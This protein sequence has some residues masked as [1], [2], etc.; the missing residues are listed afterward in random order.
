MK[1]MSSFW[2]LFCIYYSYT[3]L[4]SFSWKHC[5]SKKC[6]RMLWKSEMHPTHLE[7]PASSWAEWHLCWMLFNHNPQNST[8]QESRGRTCKVLPS[9]THSNAASPQH[10]P[11]GTPPVPTSVS[12]APSKTRFSPCLVTFFHDWYN[13]PLQSRTPAF[14]DGPNTSA[15]ERQMSSLCSH[16]CCWLQRTCTSVF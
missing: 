13:R 16:R 7:G 5:W 11:P 1:L 15:C 9:I 12:W 6:Y 3:Y 2:N 8:K 10:I 4:N 14:P